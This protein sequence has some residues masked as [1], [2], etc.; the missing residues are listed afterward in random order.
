VDVIHDLVNNET[1]AGSTDCGLWLT[2]TGRHYGT[3]SKDKLRKL[4]AREVNFRMSPQRN[5]KSEKETKYS[6]NI[7]PPL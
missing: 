1:E 4:K 6:A 3:P 5:R 2:G 7:H